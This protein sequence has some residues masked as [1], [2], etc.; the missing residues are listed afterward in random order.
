MYIISNREEISTEANN[1][2]F[3]LKVTLHFFLFLN[4]CKNWLQEWYIR[5]KKEASGEIT[6][7]APASL[8]RFTRNPLDAYFFVV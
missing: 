6:R 8:G 4:E 2:K 1:R 7:I 5:E 3:S